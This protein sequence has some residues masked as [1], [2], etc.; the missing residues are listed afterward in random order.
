MRR[1]ASLVLT[2]SVAVSVGH[3]AGPILQSIES[4]E[5]SVSVQLFAKFPK[6]GT[7]PDARI[8]VLRE[9]PGGSDRLFVNDLNG[10]LYSLD[11]TTKQ[12][13]TYI[14]FT[15][16]FPHLKVA[17]GLASGL[18]SFAFHPEFDANGKLYTIHSEVVNADF[19]TPPM[20]PPLGDFTQTSVLTEWTTDTPAAN[21]FAGSQRELLRL[22]SPGQFH[23]MGDVVFNPTAS[24]GDTDYGLLYL[25]TGDGQS[26][27][28]DQSENLQRLDSYLGSILRIDPVVDGQPL[29]GP[30]GTYSIP[31]SNPWASDDDTTTLGEVYAYG[32]RNP[33]RLAWDT[34][35]G[36][37]LATD[38]GERD[39]EEVNVVQPGGNYGWPLREG[40]FL[41]AGGA[42]PENDADLG[43]TYPAAQYDHDEG[44][45]I[46]NGVVYRGNQIPELDGMFVFGDVVN[47]RLFYTNVDELLA[48]DD[49]IPATTSEI[50]ELQL[51][52]NDQETSFLNVLSQSSGSNLTRADLRLGLD[53]SG[54]LYFMSK[55]TGEVYVV[56]TNTIF[57]PSVLDCNEDS[58]VSAG[59]LSCIIA[60]RG[61]AGLASLLTE[62]GLIPGDLDGDGQVAFLDF[63]TLA[64][65][66]G[67]MSVSYTEGD[68]DGNGE[69][70]FLDFLTLANNF[71]QSTPTASS[72]PEPAACPLFTIVASL[73]LVIRRKRN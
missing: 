43:F 17:P 32:F 3:A 15:S 52:F 65:N 39:I 29:A 13:S 25:S 60:S 19:S 69:V 35:T 44:F 40:S 10:Y 70:A 9:E 21:E 71:G 41:V 14:D 37:L 51:T 57:V 22:G 8:N 11:K 47:G 33:H 31:S 62:T 23:P 73:M 28:I 26:F 68:V 50:R 55:Q 61:P 53:D 4:S 5:S 54:G 36:A 2:I 38:I 24:A 64:N 58:S 7:R 67:A 48:A 59:D 12:P 6:T 45:A 46:T 63:L 72:V 20:A 56:S 27:N 16:K 42:L 34:E 1:S 66:F 49:G 18:V 30:N